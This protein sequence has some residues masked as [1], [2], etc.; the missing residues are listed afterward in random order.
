MAG[1][2]HTCATWQ[3]IFDFTQVFPPKYNDKC[4]F[5]TLTI[6]LFWSF[7]LLVFWRNRNKCTWNDSKIHNYYQKLTFFIL[8]SRYVPH[9]PFSISSP[10]ICLHSCEKNSSSNTEWVRVWNAKWKAKSKKK[11]TIIWVERNKMIICENEIL[12]N[13]GMWTLVLSKNVCFFHSNW[14]SSWKHRLKNWNGGFFTKDP[15]DKRIL[16]RIHG[17][18]WKYSSRRSQYEIQARD[19]CFKTHEEHFN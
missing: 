1:A 4:I 19:M 14:N 15:K 6:L 2:T 16:W 18:Q 12:V 11:N 5:L 8:C 7:S 17:K 3:V 9:L 13:S 10:K